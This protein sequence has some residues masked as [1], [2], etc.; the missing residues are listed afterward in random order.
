MLTPFPSIDGVLIRGK[1]AIP[2]ARPALEMLNAH[3]VPWILLTNGGGR[4]EQARVAELTSLLNV[5]ISES[6]L[7]QAH[8]PFRSLAS[9]Y[10]RVLVVGGDGDKCRKVAEDV[11]GFQDVVIPADI[12]KADPSVWPFHRY[13]AD[14]LA[15][16]A[17]PKRLYEHESGEAKI[18]AVLVFND[19]R[20]MGTDV[21]IVL[22]V[23]LSQHGYVGTRRD[24]HT[25][26]RSVGSGGADKQVATATDLGVPAVPIYFC[27]ND[28]LWANNYRLP[29][30][31]Q[32]AFRITVER[33]Y[34][35]LTHGAHL[36]S[37]IIG[38]PFEYTY[39]YADKVLHDWRTKRFGVPEDKDVTVFMV[40]DNPASDILGANNYG[41][42]SL[43]VRTG[44]FRDEDFGTIVAKP[45]QILDNVKEAVEF[46]I[47]HGL[48]V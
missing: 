35:E 4:S 28:L 43:L 22:D 6:Q 11:Y 24:L 37:T 33:L 46:G 27:C 2:E 26:H 21:Q 40:G 34:A 42:Y 10:H 7:V 48:Q 13:T 15:A 19:P 5:P 12:I 32:G 14:E 39:N 3:N 31:G 18:D 17:R 25:V 23:L 41:W 45:K 20:D 9:K 47:A 36:Q 38:K 30:L 16:I 1:A 8:T 29:R 44:V